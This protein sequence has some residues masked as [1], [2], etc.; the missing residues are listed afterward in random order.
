MKRDSLLNKKFGRLLVL[1][2][3]EPYI[4]PKGAKARQWLCACDCSGW[5]IATTTNLNNGNTTSCG[6]YGSM[7]AYKHGHNKKRTP[8]YNS[9]KSMKNR[10]D[11]K[12]SSQYHD[13]GGRGITYCERWSSF[14]N[15]LED[16]GERPK[17]MTLDRID[18]N[19]DYTPENCRWSNPGLQNYNSRL[20]STNTSGKSGVSWNKRKNKWEA[21]IGFQNR[22]IFLGY[23]D[24]WE[25][26]VKS[27]QAAEL[28]YYGFNK[29]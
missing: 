16:M 11:L 14:E 25:D 9:W 7:V 13:Y 10:C 6:C 8:E 21:A 29:E 1:K 3:W 5:A 17:G 20:Q 22:R 4:S 26:A 2:Q 19:G 24:K 28:E 18:M 27:R 23:F 12:G 15:F